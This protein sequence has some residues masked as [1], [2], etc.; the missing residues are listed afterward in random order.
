MTYAMFNQSPWDKFRAGAAFYESSRFVNAI[1]SSLAEIF[2]PPDD[3][4]FQAQVDKAAATACLASCVL[5]QEAMDERG[6]FDTMIL[7][8]WGFNAAAAVFQP[9]QEGL[10]ATPWQHIDHD[11][12]WSATL[13]R[14]QRFIMQCESL[15]CAVKQLDTHLRANRLPLTAD[16]AKQFFSSTVPS[17]PLNRDTTEETCAARF[18]TC[19]KYFC[20]GE[21]GKVAP[22]LPA[23]IAGI[24]EVIEDHLWAT[25]KFLW[26]QRSTP[27]LLQRLTLGGFVS[28]EIK[29]VP[30]HAGSADMGRP[31][32]TERYAWRWRDGFYGP[33]SPG[34]VHNPD[35][36][37][38]W[39]QVTYRMRADT[40]QPAPGAAGDDAVP[41][42][43]SGGDETQ[44]PPP[45]GGEPVIVP[46]PATVPAPAAATPLAPAGP[47]G[48]PGTSRSAHPPVQPPHTAPVPPAAAASPPL[49]GGAASADER[50]RFEV[51]KQ[52][53]QQQ[54]REAEN[55]AH[56]AAME[57]QE[58][59]G[60]NA[61]YKQQ[62]KTMAE[63]LVDIR[64]DL[65]E[66]E[67][68]ARR[69]REEAR[70]AKG[71]RP[72]RAASPPVPS[73]AHPAGPADLAG[74]EKLIDV[75]QARGNMIGTSRSLKHLFVSEPP[76]GTLVRLLIARTE[77][78]VTPADVP[79][80]DKEPRN[81]GAGVLKS[82]R[83]LQFRDIVFVGGQ[84]IIRPIVEWLQGVHDELRNLGIAEYVYTNGY[85]MPT[86]PEHIQSYV[87]MQE[88]I[89]TNIKRA[90]SSPR[91]RLLLPTLQRIMMP[92]DRSTLT[93]SHNIAFRMLMVVK[94]TFC[95]EAPVCVLKELSQHLLELAKLEWRYWD[96]YVSEIQCLSSLLHEFDSAFTIVAALTAMT[97]YMWDESK[98]NFTSSD[99][100][101]HKARRQVKQLLELYIDEC[102]EGKRTASW[103]SVRHQVSSILGKHSLVSAP[104]PI[105]DDRDTLPGMHAGDAS[106]IT[107][108]H[109]APLDDY[110]AGDSTGF[111]D[112]QAH[113]SYF[114]SWGD[115]PGGKGG[116]GSKG[117]GGRQDVM[118]P[119][120]HSSRSPR[121]SPRGD[122]DRRPYERSKGLPGNR[123]QTDRRDDRRDDR[124]REPARD[125][126]GKS[127]FGDDRG[128]YD[129]G[130][131]RD[132]SR[133]N[134]APRQRNSNPLV[135]PPDALP[136]P[137]HRPPTEAPPNRTF[138]PTERRCFACGQVGHIAVNCPGVRRLS[139]DNANRRNSNNE[140]SAVQAHLTSIDVLR[141]TRLSN[142]M[143]PDLDWP[144]YL[145][146]CEA[147]VAEFG[148]DEIE[149]DF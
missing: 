55:R 4:R 43:A 25:V 138:T 29:P 42:G 120:Y 143:T 141:S 7:D 119:P 10:Q 1:T 136:P 117:R 41:A 137:P 6:G 146:H 99:T 46:A 104:G 108:M 113:P 77:S 92:T 102:N 82:L 87:L 68:E 12:L 122:Y 76:A 132:R 62:H 100:Y 60:A 37:S 91:T 52:Q 149:P 50:M 118:S 95:C 53:L 133:S 103:D 126:D 36:F 105:T 86:D 28:D 106:H 128:R 96:S 135:L 88:Q 18:P 63:D 110:W 59:K 11:R 54:V 75:G 109:V 89:A 5:V 44:L 26:L 15:R 97:D 131:S 13:T 81:F 90:L 2:A 61:V 27:E 72:E 139:S 65:G 14:L 21:F 127:Q 145:A 22:M 40:G 34:R 116:K 129:R 74:S 3:P 71:V 80:W 84:P 19:A 69:L 58:V 94:Y 85:G 23:L 17:N 45:P 33:V 48:D 70:A 16:D 51:E 39:S 31:D 78:Y 47:D 30:V 124:R 57:A 56:R 115:S 140:P 148:T 73:P 66:A 125:R 49:P 83:D 144:E 114:A 134:S 67:N 9:I 98:I 79:R 123:R 130:S 38:D 111:E 107:A 64:N 93:S 24:S 101:E 20:N 35:L 147:H 121:G 112:A 32:Q 142:G 8:T